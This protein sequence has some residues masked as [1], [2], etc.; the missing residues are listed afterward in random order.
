MSLV[1]QKFG[2][3]SVATPQA[4]DRLLHQVKQCQ[5]EGYEVVVVVSAMGRKGDPYATDTLIGL[6]EQI[7]PHI[8]L[9][10][11]DLLM[12]CGEIIS[13]AVLSHFLD[14][15][16]VPAEPLT[17]YQAR[18]LTT[19]AFSHSDILDIDPTV[20]THF[21]AQGKV[22]IV[23]GFQGITWGGKITTLGRGGSDT[24]AVELGGYLDAKWVDIF[25]DVPGVAIVDPR[26][27]PDAAYLE[28]IS[29]AEMYQLAAHGAKVIH[30]RAV[31]AAEKFMLPVRVR[32]T[33]SDEAGT[34]ISN[35]PCARHKKVFGLPVEKEICSLKIK[36]EDRPILDKVR[37]T[38]LIDNIQDGFYKA[39]LKKEHADT[40]RAALANSLLDYTDNMDRLSVLFHP[41]DQEAIKATI[42]NYLKAHLPGV[43]DVFWFDNSASIFM[44]HEHVQAIVQ[45]L[46]KLF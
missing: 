7:D 30:P 19:N 46:Y 12:S 18:I 8:D 44:E 9:A 33:F 23:A 5:A 6:L 43:H 2:G 14:I 25:T 27:V 39:Y 11:K 21:L 4:R 42:N 22:V 1:V 35:T 20:I 34:L 15:H 41:E 32:S 36:V 29:Y 37:K 38:L 40:V 28:N 26:L 17:G 24:T 45:D 31:K 10:K 3:T 13:C 16:G